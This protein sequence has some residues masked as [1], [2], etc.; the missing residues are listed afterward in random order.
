MSRLFM[1][2]K[3]FK[4]ACG[5]ILSA[6]LIIS[7]CDF[8]GTMF[9]KSVEA[10]EDAAGDVVDSDEQ[11]ESY[12][13]TFD[14]DEHASISVYKTKDFSEENK[15][16]D[17]QTTALTR[18][19]ETGEI[20]NIDGQVN[21]IVI[22]DEGYNVLSVSA[23]T[24]TYKN[25]NKFED[26]GT[27]NGYGFT[28][29][30]CDTTIT[31]R[32]IAEGEATPEPTS[33]PAPFTV[34]FD[35]D[36]HASV[37]VYKTKNITDENKVGDDQTEALTRDKDSGEPTG[38]EGQINFVVVTEEGYVVDSVSATEDTYNKIK[39]LTEAGVDNAYAVTKITADSVVTI[40]TKL[41]SETEPT[42]EPIADPT[43]EPTKAPA[44]TQ[45]PETDHYLD[46]DVAL[47]QN[48]GSYDSL[49]KAY[50]IDDKE[51]GDESLAYARL[52]YLFENNETAKVRITG[53][54]T[55][56]TGFRIWIGN[57]PNSFS[58]V[59]EYKDANLEKGD[60][61]L[62]ATIKTNKAAADTITIKA[63]PEWAGGKGYISGLSIKTL[64]VCYPERGD[65]P[66]YYPTIPTLEPEE[67]RAPEET[68]AP[69]ETRAP[70]QTAAPTEA[71]GQ[72]T[73]EPTKAP[74]IQAPTKA[75]EAP[76]QTQTPVQN[77]DNIGQNVS[78]APAEI[79]APGRVKI[80]SV[81]KVVAK[82]PGIL[83]KW[84]KVAGASGYKIV[85]KLG[86]KS[87]T[88]TVKKG[89]KTKYTIKNLKK[90]KK[91][92]ISIYAYIKT[93]EGTLRGKTSKAK[94]IKL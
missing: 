73:T 88:I 40:R 93:D 60:F 41:A 74:E 80:K 22:P 5:V 1:R 13:V 59:A 31:V 57:G 85:Y 23:P 81:K 51:K 32:T 68:Q 47:I 15:V 17:N 25:I 45:E 19:K 6:A 67:T 49:S 28:K 46:I 55:G 7:A 3:K 82:K 76:V 12:T 48:S 83:V 44:P 89:S 75:P 30:K 62:V 39:V 16:G 64:Q 66:D 42:D 79:A 33:T 43:A 71:P 10:G 27:P 53:T 87:K 70:E 65:H 63:F 37:S 58:N 61:D 77:V 2:K 50:V 86:K 56:D 84:G 69:E 94:S 20:T 92:I 14:V 90:G 26:A 11:A 52:P 35:V 29:I 38:A 36:E 34:T 18:N 8:G 54:Y 24:G 78:E 9:S 21:F 91:Y 72:T 4:R